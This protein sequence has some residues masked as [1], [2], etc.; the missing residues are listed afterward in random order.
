MRNQVDYTATAYD[1]LTR[2]IDAATDP[3]EVRRVSDQLDACLRWYDPRL[4]PDNTT[5]CG[6]VD[7]PGLLPA[8]HHTARRIEVVPLRF[9]FEVDDKV[10]PFIMTVVRVEWVFGLVNP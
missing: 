5:N 8:P 2:L 3:D 10:H 6:R 1:Q 9:Y 4:D 7:G